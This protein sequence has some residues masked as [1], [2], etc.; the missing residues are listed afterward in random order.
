MYQCEARAI[1]INK[2]NG[3]NKILIKFEDN[4]FITQ[5]ADHDHPYYWKIDLKNDNN[6]YY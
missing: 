5:F 3:G 6:E 2:K 1:N 4:V